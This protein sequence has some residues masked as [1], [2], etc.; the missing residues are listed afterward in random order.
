MPCT[1]GRDEADRQIAAEA[2]KRAN[3]TTA[4]LC[5][6]LRTGIRL[7]EHDAWLLEHRRRDRDRA[8]DL[9]MS[10]QRDAEKR[11]RDEPAPYEARAERLRLTIKRV[12]DLQASDP[13]TTDLY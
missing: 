13:L 7:P 6:L 8:I 4:L 11:M 5:S 12:Q 1:D 2:A 10:V 9:A 3:R